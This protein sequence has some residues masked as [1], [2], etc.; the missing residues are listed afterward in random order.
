MPVLAGCGARMS[1]APDAE[2][3]ERPSDSSPL[4]TCSAV[5]KQ[6]WIKVFLSSLAQCLKPTTGAPHFRVFQ[7]TLTM[8][9]PTGTFS[10][11]SWGQVSGAG[12]ALT[13]VRSRGWAAISATQR[14][15]ALCIL[16]TTWGS[17]TGGNFGQSRKQTVLFVSTGSYVLGT[18]S[19]R[20][21][22]KATAARLGVRWQ[23]GWCWVEPRGLHADKGEGSGQTKV[24]WREGELGR[25]SR[26]RNPFC[27]HSPQSHSCQGS[28][29]CCD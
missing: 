7:N 3:T 29:R 12:R 21:E 15:F 11:L 8:V 20:T 24:R 18:I 27:F 19:V 6:P 5:G 28:D 14:N 13:S 4:P 25:S 9:L 17:S 16:G 22:L 23:R 2:W 10:A 26:L 1:P